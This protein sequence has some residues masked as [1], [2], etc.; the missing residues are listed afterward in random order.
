MNPVGYRFNVGGIEC[1]AVRGGAFTVNASFLFTNAPPDT[2]ADA[3]RAHDQADRITVPITN[4]LIN[5]GEQLVLVDTGRSKGKDPEASTLQQNLQTLGIAGADI[6]VVIITHGHLDHIGGLTNDDGRL[7]FPNAR[8]IMSKVEWDFWTSE[9]GLAMLDA[10]RAQ[11]LRTQF[12]AIRDRLDLVEQAQ[13]IVPGVHV[14]MAPG[15]T[16]G[17]MIVHVVS[18]EERLLHIVDTVI[19]PLHMEHP[20]WMAGADQIPEQVEAT[21]RRIFE[22]A[23][24]EQTLLFANHFSFPGLGRVVPNEQAWTWQPI[25]YE[26]AVDASDLAPLPRAVV[27]HGDP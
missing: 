13:E 22:Q 17:H 25:H 12:G 27:D 2:L 7:A 20:T 8:Y 10:A 19:Q 16:P 23:A 1:T 6:D 5:T 9:E 4:L 24:A 11:A 21:R 14:M 26:Q 3:M 18:G 15:H